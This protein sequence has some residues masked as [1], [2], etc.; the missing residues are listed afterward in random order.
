MVATASVERRAT[1]GDI[2]GT[3]APATGSAGT[4]AELMLQPEHASCLTHAPQWTLRTG[5]TRRRSW[6]GRPL[7]L[8][9]PPRAS[10]RAPGSPSPA[11]PDRT[12]APARPDMSGYKGAGFNCGQGVQ[13]RSAE[14][15]MCCRT[16][17][18]EGSMSA[19]WRKDLP[20][21]FRGRS[22]TPRSSAMKTTPSC[23]KPKV[24]HLGAVGDLHHLRP[25]A[26][27]IRLPLHVHHFQTLQTA[28]KSASACG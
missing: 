7:Q 2:T 18:S 1:V 3:A 25:P 22:L 13:E 19:V 21:G 20:V 8:P 17:S 27:R 11:G 6:S 5:R 16:S 26:R 9:A 15:D 24:A 28:A 12:A 14:P 4:T 10:P 23:A